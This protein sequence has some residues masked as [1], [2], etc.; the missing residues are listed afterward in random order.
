M[1]PLLLQGPEHITRCHQQNTKT[2]IN[3][4]RF[5]F[6]FSLPFNLSTLRRIPPTPSSRAD[7]QAGAD[8]YSE[9]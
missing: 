7:S 3:N 9:R 6:T 1:D 8:R 2:L 5:D 4:P